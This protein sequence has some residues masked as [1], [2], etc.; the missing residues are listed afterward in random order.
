MHLTSFV[1]LLNSCISGTSVGFYPVRIN[2]NKAPTLINSI[3]DC[4]YADLQ[5]KRAGG[6]AACSLVL[7]PISTKCLVSLPWAYI[8]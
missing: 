1:S 7:C 2:A 3:S 4:C 6:N 8:A 5:S